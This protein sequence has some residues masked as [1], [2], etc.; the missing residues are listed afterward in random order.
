MLRI[1]LIDRRTPSIRAE[2][3]NGICK[4]VACTRLRKH[5]GVQVK[6]FDITE[7]N[8]GYQSITQEI[9]KILKNPR[10]VAKIINVPFIVWPGPALFS[11]DARRIHSPG[12]GRE[13]TLRVFVEIRRLAD[14]LPTLRFD[15][16]VDA[17]NPII[18]KSY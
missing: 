17:T 12:F 9:V 5:D 7:P 6:G 14:Y 18:I 4:D 3:S 1:S 16:I 13:P 11:V 10:S 8:G 15:R 2:T